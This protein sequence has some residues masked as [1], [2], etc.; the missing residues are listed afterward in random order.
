MFCWLLSWDTTRTR[1]FSPVSLRF[2]QS[3]VLQIESIYLL[4]AM[5]WWQHWAVLKVYFFVK[6]T[7]VE[8]LGIYVP[9]L[10]QF[11]GT[12]AMN[13]F[14]MTNDSKFYK[15]LMRDLWHHNS[16]DWPQWVLVFVW[17]VVCFFKIFPFLIS[18]DS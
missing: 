14:P 18:Y 9:R 11:W 3:S 12:A 6:F 8:L 16:N 2:L 4:W 5:I 1:L 15:S 13:L 17:L 7:K 10:K